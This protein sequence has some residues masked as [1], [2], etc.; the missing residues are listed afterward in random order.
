MSYKPRQYFFNTKIISVLPLLWMNV[1]LD[2]ICMV[3]I[4]LWATGRKR[5][6]QNENTCLRRESNQ[7]PLPFQR[8][9][10]TTRH[11]GGPIVPVSCRVSSKFC[12]PISIAVSM[13]SKMCRRT[14]C[15]SWLLLY[16][17]VEGT[18]VSVIYVQMYKAGPTVWLSRLR[19]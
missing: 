9:A 14:I 6:I 12:C 16:A 8:A 13:K 17:T 4:E 11:E 3:F 18:R 10:L 19:H 15:L 5:K 1:M 7:W 2:F